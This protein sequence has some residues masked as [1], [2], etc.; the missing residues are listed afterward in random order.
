[1]RSPDAA[2]LRALAAIGVDVQYILTGEQAAS[3]LTQ[4]EKD[5]LIKC[6]NLSRR[7]QICVV[8]MIDAMISQPD[9][10]IKDSI[11]HP[12]SVRANSR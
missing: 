1:V 4:P 9:D 10:A 3:A 2:Y 12:P 11:T 5:L 8:A 6:R 7:D